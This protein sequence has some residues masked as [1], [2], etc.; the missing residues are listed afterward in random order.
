MC[1]GRP[2]RTVECVPVQKQEVNSMKK[3]SKKLVV[4]IVVVLLIAA[5]GAAVWY[6][7]NDSRKS[8]FVKGAEKVEKWGK[9]V[10]RDTKNLFK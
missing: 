1:G 3:A 9:D 2:D 6:A 10:G 8:G 4:T 5:A 7:V